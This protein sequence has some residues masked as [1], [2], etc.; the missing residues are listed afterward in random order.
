MDLS[1]HFASVS[2]HNAEAQGSS[3]HYSS[4]FSAAGLFARARMC[5]FVMLLM[6][7]AMWIEAD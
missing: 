5:E 3:D 1:K 6:V 7:M 2:H 4:S